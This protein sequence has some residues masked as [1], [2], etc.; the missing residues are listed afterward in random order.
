MI[1][2]DTETALIEPG[3][4]AP[5][6][7]CL[8]FAED[9]SDVAVA[10]VGVDPVEGLLR[11]I[12]TK[13]ICGHNIA[14]DLLVIT[15]EYPA[16]WPLVFQAYDEDRVHDTMTRQKLRWISVGQLRGQKDSLEAIAAL[17]GVQKDGSDPWRLRYAELRGSPFNQWP[18]GAKQYA[19]HDVEATRSVFL[20]QGDRMPDEPRQERAAFVMHCIG[21]AGVHTDPVQV[22]RF[23]AQVHQEHERNR[24]W[25]I[26]AGLVRRDGSR[27]TKAA[28]ARMVDVVPEPKRTKKGGICLDEDACLQSGDELLQAYQSFG[29]FKNL[30]SR[31]QGLKRPI[32]NPRFDSLIETG[33]TSC[34][35][36]PHGYQIQ[37][38]RRASGERE[39]FVPASGN[40]FIACDYDSFELCALA[41]ICY[42]VVGHSALGDAINVGIDPHL[43]AAATALGLPYKEAVR[44]YQ[45]GDVRLKDMRQGMKISNF[46]YP[47][48]MGSKS[49][50]SYARGFGLNLSEERSQELREAWLEAW[51]EMELYFEWISD[52]P[53]VPV[54]RGDHPRDVCTVIHPMSDRVRGGCSYTQACNLYFQGL[55]ADAAKA[56]G[57]DLL[58]LTHGTGWKIWNFVH[59][60]YL[61]EGP[62]SEA[63]DMALE[64]EATMVSA[65]ERWMPNVRIGASPT[66]M[67][68]WSKDAQQIFNASGKLIPW[69]GP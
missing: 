59:D 57:W 30:L 40:V 25:L 44:R 21:A 12:L 69:E 32:I 43:Q 55:A 23:E 56:A 29:S 35:T 4:L 14:F 11:E 67:R 53:W 10:V 54:I 58:R 49:F 50:I 28:Q 7:T 34:A 24:E 2:L 31:L 45:A 26:D 51:P 52:R 61:F 3:L 36:G 33:R 22:A 1:Y 63:S 60:E 41:Q 20:S 64:I 39:C 17:Y 68:R 16:L 65:A 9:D 8:Q 42:W 19:A 13:D 6:M 38:M 18:E 37:N 47:G 46:G 48:G 27:D 5:P 62:E 66:I 15:T